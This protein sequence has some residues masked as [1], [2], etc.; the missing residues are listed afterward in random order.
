MGSNH[1]SKTNLEMKDITVDENN[2]AQ[3]FLT[4]MEY[5][6]HRYANQLTVFKSQHT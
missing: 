1:G 3:S 5:E 6:E 4:G 2:N